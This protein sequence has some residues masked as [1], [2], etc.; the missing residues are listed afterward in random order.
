M[1]NLCLVFK[2][3]TLK[4]VCALYSIIKIKIR[5]EYYLKFDKIIEL[6]LFDFQKKKKAKVSNKIIYE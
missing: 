2:R 1:N 3:F 4:M 6:K 5:L